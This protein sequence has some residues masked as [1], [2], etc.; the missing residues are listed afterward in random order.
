MA[1]GG[2][3]PPIHGDLFDRRLVA[4]AQIEDIAIITRGWRL[5]RHDLRIIRP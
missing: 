5:E 2:G 3:L 1:Q 4:Q